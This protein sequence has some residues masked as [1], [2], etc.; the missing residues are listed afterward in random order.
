MAR[1]DGPEPEHTEPKEQEDPG[2]PGEAVQWERAA[3][4]APG[5]TAP[6]SVEPIDEIGELVLDQ[7]VRRSE[8]AAPEPER[9][10]DEAKDVR[11]NFPLDAFIVPGGMARMPA[12]YETEVAELVARRLDDLAQQLRSEGLAALGHDASDIDELSRVFAA[13]IAGYL[14]RDA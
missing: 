13:V 6:R 11:T 3:F 9:A 1:E 10:A 2:A 4:T 12:G 7:V 5:Y 14:A 8:E